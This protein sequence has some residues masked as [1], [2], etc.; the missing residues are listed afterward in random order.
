MH[1]T[2]QATDPRI[3]FLG[4]CLAVALA[5]GLRPFPAPV[6]LGSIELPCP[7][8]VERRGQG[9]SCLSFREAAALGVG[10]G[11]VLP[12]ITAHGALPAGPPG[13][14]APMRLLALRVPIDL[15]AATTEELVALPG[16]GPALARRIEAAR[17]LCRLND[18]AR[19]PG[20]GR[21]RAAQLAPFVG[22]DCVAPSAQVPYERHDAATGR[23]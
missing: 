21:R 8:P 13:R 17:P 9:V 10:A 14:M 4:L 11:E 7:V 3:F 23:D 16:I 2:P 18:L 5:V 1:P 15:N 22:R 20:I 6:L 12:A 19:V